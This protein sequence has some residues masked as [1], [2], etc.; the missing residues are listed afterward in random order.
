MPIMVMSPDV[1]SFDRMIAWR[2]EPEIFNLR[3]MHAF[4]EIAQT[5]EVRG[6]PVHIK[7]DT[8]M[9]RLGF[10]PFE[11]DALLDDLQYNPYVH[12]ASI[13]S[14]L[15]ASDD[16]AQDDF[17]N[18]QADAFE[19]M[20][21]RIMELLPHKPLLHLCNSAA[22]ER[23][24]RL[25]YDMIRLGLG[26][27]G[28]DSSGDMQQELM[29]VG[30]LKTT[31]AQIKSIPPGETVGYNRRAVA[32]NKLRIAT[33]SIGYAD[34]YPRSLGNA[35]AHV[36]IHGRPAKVI[37]VVCMDMCMVDITDI[38]E[39][40]EGDDVIVFSPELPVT[41]LATW[42]GTI[43]YEIMTGVSQRVKRVYVN[44]G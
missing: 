27:Y 34:G 13:F 28:I 41:Q 9:H 19:R 7:L 44:E 18:A 15:A 30:T 10:Q 24:P 26:L 5:L 29:Q 14:H 43:P 12:I 35:K 36:L 2:L 31:I 16:P 6:Y 22:I 33:I 39:A 17:T 37:G 3:S 42:A 4:T 32:E 20:S 23:H 11:I 25:H 8:G 40:E 21:Q 1:E 38:P